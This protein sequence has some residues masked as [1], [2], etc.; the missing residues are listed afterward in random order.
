MNFQS[1]GPLYRMVEVIEDPPRDAVQAPGPEEMTYVSA[2][3]SADDDDL[4]SHT[5]RRRLST[6][7]CIHS[8]CTSITLVSMLG[9]PT[10]PALFCRECG[11]QGALVP[12]N[13]LHVNGHPLSLVPQ[14]PRCGCFLR[15][16]RGQLPA[17]LASLIADTPTLSEQLQAVLQ[18]KIGSGITRD[19]DKPPLIFTDDHAEHGRLTHSAKQLV[20]REVLVYLSKCTEEAL[21]GSIIITAD[22]KLSDVV[23]LL[24][25]QLEV[26]PNAELFRASLGQQLRV[27]LNK[28]QHKRPALPFFPCKAHCLIVEEPAE[29]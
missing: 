25:D 27:P 12:L 24:R 19:P 11:T 3:R 4:N 14:L 18:E 16:H 7:F 15:G 23:S 5:F 2:S 8:Q 9:G 17:T 10:T 26:A 1:L 29:A 22:L 13:E 6:P 20:S 28:R 21:L